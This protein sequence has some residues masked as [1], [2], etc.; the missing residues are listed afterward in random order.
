[1]DLGGLWGAL[2]RLAAVAVRAFLTTLLV[3]ALAGLALAGLSYHL[4][5]D[6]PGYGAAAGVLAFVEALAAGVFLGQ[7]RAL[8]AVLAHA[9][10][11]FHV[12]RE[13]VRLV[14]ERLGAAPAAA[15]VV[16]RLPLAQAEERLRGAVGGL[17]AAPP[18]GGGVT[19]WLRRRASER[20]LSL[21]EV[22][23][24]ARF[25]QAGADGTVD[26]AAV[27]ADLAARIDE[28]LTARLRKP[29]M[30]AAL[31]A[32]IGLPVLVFAQAHVLRSLAEGR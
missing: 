11:S 29:L 24:L 9:L 4:L 27:Q 12:G 23:T 18:A 19:G 31:L 14:F 17:V 28:L 32:A 20:L 5:R 26:L 7:Q 15:G 1:M 2:A 30:I 22:V 6:H 25:R 8:A 3:L 10:K 13:A 16:Q 21:V